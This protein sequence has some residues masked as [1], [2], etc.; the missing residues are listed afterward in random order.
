MWATIERGL[1]I[2]Y[3]AAGVLVLPLA[4]LL[5]LQWPLREWIGA[6]SREANDLAQVLFALY[7]SVAVSAATRAHAHLAADTLARHYPARVRWRLARIASLVILMPWGAFLLVAMGSPALLSL[8][9][10]ERFPETFNPGYFAIK[11]AVILLALLV[12]VQAIID[13]WQRAPRDTQC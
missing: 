13:A 2:V 11:L 1:G 3:R 8:M 5:F 6:W 10:L 12:V 7:V 4:F 9:Q